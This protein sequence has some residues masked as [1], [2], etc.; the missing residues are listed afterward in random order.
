VV[1]T[2]ARRRD[3]DELRRRLGTLRADSPASWGTM[4]APQMVC[5]LSDAFR[6]ALGQKAVTGTSGR[7]RRTVIKWMALYAPLKWPAGIVTSPEIDQTL[8]GTKPTAF[9]DDVAEA[10]RLLEVVAQA[11]GLDTVPHPVFGPMSHGDWMRWGYAHTDH[12]LRQFGA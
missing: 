1:R 7:L 11:R 3:V 4:S 8:G 5:H 9:A 12:H 10:A 6:M 2:L